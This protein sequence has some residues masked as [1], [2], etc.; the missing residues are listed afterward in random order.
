MP[1]REVSCFFLGALI[2][3][4][5][6]TGIKR[7]GTLKKILFVLNTEILYWQWFSMDL[8]VKGIWVLGI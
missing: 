1:G 2:S 7:L 3:L 6:T 5:Y 8:P 4:V